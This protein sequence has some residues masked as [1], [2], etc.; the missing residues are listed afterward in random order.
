LNTPYF[1]IT[2]TNVKLNGY[3]GSETINRIQDHSAIG[4]KQ[5]YIPTLPL[6]WQ[7]KPEPSPVNEIQNA[8]TGCMK[9][10]IG[11]QINDAALKEKSK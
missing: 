5:L 8:I 6:W 2:C 4:K 10:C 1:V 9:E 11:K 7:Y 3:H